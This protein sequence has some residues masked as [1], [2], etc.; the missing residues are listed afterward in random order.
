MASKPKRKR[1][2]TGAGT[3]AIAAPRGDHESIRMREIK[4]GWIITREGARRGKYFSEDEFSATKPV[5]TAGPPI[6]PV[7]RSSRNH[8]R[9]ARR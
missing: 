7:G 1:R 6:K 4:N 2:S 8:N 9:G 3:V 5:I